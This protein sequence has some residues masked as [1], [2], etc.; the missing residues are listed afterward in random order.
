M[1]SGICSRAEDVHQIRQSQTD[2]TAILAQQ[3]LFNPT[4]SLLRQEAAARP[5]HPQVVRSRIAQ[6]PSSE[7]SKL[8]R[9]DQH[10]PVPEEA[11][12]ERIP[13][14]LPLAGHED[15]PNSRRTARTGQAAE[16]L[17]D[18]AG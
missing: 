15:P 4:S 12:G 10:P 5:V 3:H 6:N 17:H 9:Q 18:S 2:H 7:K 1:Q 11:A 8:D 13:N 14:R 16:E